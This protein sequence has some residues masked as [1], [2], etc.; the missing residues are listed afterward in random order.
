MLQTSGKQLYQKLDPGT[1]VFLRILR[2]F[3]EHLFYGTPLDDCRSNSTME[4]T[5]QCVKYVQSLLNHQ[6]VSKSY[7]HDCSSINNYQ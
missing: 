3:S 2:N 7:E 4:T 6:K 5:D 1:G